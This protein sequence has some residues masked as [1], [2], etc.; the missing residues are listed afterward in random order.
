MWY[1]CLTFYINMLEYIGTIQAN[2]LLIRG[3]RVHLLSRTGSPTLNW[4]I[5]K[6]V[7]R[8]F[9]MQL[10]DKQSICSTVSGNWTIT[11]P[12][13]IRVSSY[14]RG[15]AGVN[16]T[17][18]PSFRAKTQ[19]LRHIRTPFRSQTDVRNTVDQSSS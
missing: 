14:I 1:Y 2:R 13:I 10:T 19:G 9:T 4:Y 16:V 15:R 17:N 12:I 5:V 18:D 3:L 7:T 11:L 6:T 8:K